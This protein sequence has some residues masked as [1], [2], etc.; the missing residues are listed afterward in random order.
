MRKLSVVCIA[1]AALSIG[2]AHAEGL[3]LG[4]L[5]GTTTWESGPRDESGKNVGVVVRYTVPVA[6]GITLGA[7]VAAAI[8]GV[9]FGDELSHSSAEAEETLRAK[10]GVDWSVD[11]LVLG[12]VDLSTAVT[13]Y[14]AGGLSWARVSASQR[15]SVV[16]DQVEVV[17]ADESESD[18][19]LGY[20]LVAGVEIPASER[21]A[22]FGQ[23]E[24]AD[25]GDVGV[26]AFGDLAALGVR[27]GALYRF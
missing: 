6:G 16:T 9:E 18:V 15:G 24:Y 7:H 26:S 11:A 27:L 21:V 3:S 20:K 25:Y 5:V 12:A 23:V 22:I 2:T 13:A 8:E 17:F 14:A 19:A 10:G 1:V 4:G